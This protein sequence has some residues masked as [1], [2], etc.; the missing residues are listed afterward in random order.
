MKQRPN[1]VT[2]LLTAAFACVLLALGGCGDDDSGQ[3]PLR[4]ADGPIPPLHGEGRWFTDAAG[5]VVLLHGFN[6]VS[7]SAPYYPAAFGFGEDDAA[8]L[9]SEGFNAIRLGVD[10]RGLMPQPGEVSEEYIENIAASVDVL[11]EHEIFV[12]LD[13]HQDGFAP[14]YNGN[15]LPDWMAVDDGLPN[16]PEAVFPLYYIQNPAMQ[17]AF[18]SFWTNRPGPGGIGLQDYYAQG[19]ERVAARFAD[20]PWVIG[21][22]LMNEPWPGADWQPCAAPPEG[23]PDLEQAYLAPFHH[24]MGQVIRAITRDQLVFAEPFVLFNFGQAPTTLPGSE[25]QSA[26]SFHSYAADVAGEKAVLAFGVEAAVRDGAPALVTEFGATTDPALLNRLTS[27]M[28]AQIL[29]WLDWAYNESIIADPSQP[30][31][32]DNLRSVDAFAALVRP[33][34]TAVAGTPTRVSFDPQTARFEL[35]YTT[36]APTGSRLDEDLVTVVS[37]PSRHYRDGYRAIV[38]GGTVTSA[39]CSTL[40]TLVADPGA[41]TVS[42]EI[43]PSDESCD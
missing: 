9:V 10:F 38:Q 27:Q 21:Y 24:K 43:S 2:R 22:D 35:V 37:V 29:P 14:K 3:T 19:V 28:E 20:N 42:L 40:L 33:Y 17:R 25:P 13:F 36:T 18:E 12:L 16:P 5:R 8:F 34:P 23:C 6:Q 41:D 26:L 30:A 39:P 4:G 7:K 31:G 1:R 32:P 11:A 15:G